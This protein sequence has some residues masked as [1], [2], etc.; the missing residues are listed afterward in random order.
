LEKN[1]R[2]KIEVKKT[3]EIKQT[4]NNTKNDFFGGKMRH[5][6]NKEK[7]HTDRL[8]Y[9]HLTS[10]HLKENLLKFSAK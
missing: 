1:I 5:I 10:T 8:L 6:L 3:R 9:R 4:Q 7:F 2:G